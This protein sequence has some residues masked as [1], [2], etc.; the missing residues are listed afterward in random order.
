METV[1]SEGMRAAVLEGFGQALCRTE[2]IVARHG[3]KS[4]ATRLSGKFVYEVACAVQRMLFQQYDRPTV[5]KVDEQGEKSSGEWLVDACITEKISSDFVSRIVFAMESE[6]E[7]SK[8]AFNEDFAKLVHLNASVKL[9]LNGLKH[10]EKQGT[11]GAEQYIE[12]RI[13]Y[14]SRIVR[15]TRA[16]GQIFLGFWPSPG[17]FKGDSF[18]DDSHVSAW[19]CLPCHLK[20]IRLFEFRGTFVE[21]RGCDL[22]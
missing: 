8:K 19:Q 21:V 13:D 2:A 18:K 11:R 17:K 3:R 14:A 7:T 20:T 12:R 1:S 10:R 4:A 16:S 15:R 9:Y 6:S 22:A 5:I